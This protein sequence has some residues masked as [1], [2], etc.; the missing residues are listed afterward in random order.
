MRLQEMQLLE[1][2][3]HKDV[4][5]LYRQWKEIKRNTEEFRTFIQQ[6]VK[7]I[8][9]RPYDFDIILDIGLGVTT[10]LTETIRMRRGELYEM[11]ESRVREE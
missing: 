10:E 7:E 8:R 4:E 5:H 3:T 2:I 11:F 6:F 9:V 1:P